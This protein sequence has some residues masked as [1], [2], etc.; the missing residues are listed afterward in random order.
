M[1]TKLF[2][3]IGIIALIMFGLGISL[4]LV[5]SHFSFSTKTTFKSDITLSEGDT[6]NLDVDAT[7]PI[8]KFFGFK[9]SAKV[10]CKVIS[11]DGGL[12]KLK[13]VPKERGFER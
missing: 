4:A 6:L 7:T 5:M 2:V 12:V 9:V 10:S 13:C 3:T 11:A 8:L 1:N